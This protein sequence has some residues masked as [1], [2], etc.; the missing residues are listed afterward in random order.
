MSATLKKRLDILVSDVQAIQKELFLTKIGRL[1][2]SRR[3]LTAWAV[4][5]QKV[6]AA[7]DSVSAVDEIASPREKQW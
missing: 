7:W 6:S 2:R 5:R 1:H 3:T 4:L